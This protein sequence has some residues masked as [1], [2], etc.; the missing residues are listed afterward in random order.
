MELRFQIAG[1]FDLIGK[2]KLNILLVVRYLRYLRYPG[3]ATEEVKVASHN[4]SSSKPIVGRHLALKHAG[5]SGA[6]SKRGVPVGLN[7]NFFGEVRLESA[8]AMQTCKVEVIGSSEQRMG[9]NP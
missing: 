3:S 8:S 9:A 4:G 2:F 5:Q 6:F 1:A 7:Q